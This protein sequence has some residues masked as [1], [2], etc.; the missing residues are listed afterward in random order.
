MISTMP[1]VPGRA[2]RPHG[3]G[4][5]V[6]LQAR[7]PAELKA[8]YDEAAK[9]RGLSLSLYFEQLIELDPLAPKVVAPQEEDPL[10]TP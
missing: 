4:G 5:K 1:W 10:L 2:T 3:Q 9:V 6:P 8:R 7:V